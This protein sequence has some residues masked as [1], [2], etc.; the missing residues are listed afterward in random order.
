MPQRP[1]CRG[2]GRAAQDAQHLSRHGYVRKTNS[3]GFWQTLHDAAVVIVVAGFVTVVL[4]S[5]RRV[6]YQL[7]NDTYTYNK[8]THRV[9]CL[10]E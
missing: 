2:A 1:H 4:A 5:M 3:A 6:R 7:K 9:F 8:N 10:G